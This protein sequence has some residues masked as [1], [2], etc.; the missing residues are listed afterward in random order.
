M[1]LGD[2]SL[3]K[4]G[5]WGGDDWGDELG[6]GL[7]KLGNFG[8]VNWGKALSKLGG[9]FGSANWGGALARLGNAFGKG[10]WGSALS[11]IG[12]AF[13]GG[14]DWG[15]DLGRDL[16]GGSWDT[17]MSPGWE[18]GKAIGLVG[19]GNRLKWLSKSKMGRGLRKRFAGGFTK[20]SSLG[21]GLSG[22]I[23]SLGKKLFQIGGRPAGHLGGSFSLGGLRG[24]GS[25]PLSSV[26]GDREKGRLSMPDTGSQL[27]GI[28]DRL[29][30]DF[31]ERQDVYEAIERYVRARLSN[32]RSAYQR[33]RGDLQRTLGRMRAGRL[34]D[35]INQRRAIPRPEALDMGSSFVEL[36]H[37]Q[38]LHEAI[39]RAQQAISGD[40]A[41]QFENRSWQEPVS[42]DT[43]DFESEDWGDD[44]MDPDDDETLFQNKDWGEQ[45]MDPED[46]ETVFQE[47]EPEKSFMDTDDDETVLQKEGW[48]EDA[49]DPDDDE[50][51][52]QN[53]DWGGQF[54]DP[55]D[56]PTVFRGKRPK[57]FVETED[58]DTVFRHR[59]WGDV[60]DPDDDPTVF[61]KEDPE[62]VMDPEDDVT[63][64][65]PQERQELFI[66][67]EDD[68]T[69]FQNQDMPAASA[70]DDAERVRPDDDIDSVADIDDPKP[71]VE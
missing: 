15:K 21:K 18:K 50:T 5:S 37:R 33:A 13:G 17:S 19:R 27:G 24:M 14:D 60:M 57:Q 67:P 62:D 26:V 46:D 38:E 28:G 54:M 40:G 35:M 10:D 3:G 44:V 51:L 39:T 29:V 61:Q 55:D 68:E 71:Q 56:D 58:D 47:Q 49:M 43:P 12:R 63:V 1:G 22:N 48:G 36:R 2:S 8:K 66:D 34:I 41:G 32:D 53:K 30:G 25:G 52:F 7:T 16:R 70:D 9:A 69:A 64:F 31:R 59:D 23:G 20:F 4:S 45:F 42:D 65:Q 6:K 11:R